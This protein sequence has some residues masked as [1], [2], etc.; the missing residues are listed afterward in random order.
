MS[1][2]FVNS[3][4]APFRRVQLSTVEMEEMPKQEGFGTLLVIFGTRPEAVKLMPL[5][6]ELRRRGARVRVCTTGQHREMLQHV[7]DVFDVVP[8][9]SL[10]LMVAN[11][12]L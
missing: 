10:D 7:L 2:R 4:G 5:I 3:R 8:D 12:S 9:V 1:Y 11:Q 6:A